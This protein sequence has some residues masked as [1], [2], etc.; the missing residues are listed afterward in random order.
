MMSAGMRAVLV[1]SRLLLPRVPGF[2]FV[3]GK[4]YRCAGAALPSCTRAAST[5][6]LELS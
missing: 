4:P 1:M 2:A 3:T 6:S 5:S